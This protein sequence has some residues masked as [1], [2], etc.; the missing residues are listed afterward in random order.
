MRM[1]TDSVGSEVA[2][3]VV[4]GFAVHRA[5]QVLPAA[6]V[7]SRK[8]RTLLGLLA[9]HRD[10]VPADRITAAV[11]GGAP[12]RAPAANMA[13]LVSR[14]RTVLGRSAITGGPAG[15]R[16]GDQ[17]CVDL[18][19]AA[20]LT[21]A[22]EQHIVIQEADLAFTAARRATDLL[23]RG[24]VL[25]DHRDSWWAEEARALHGRLL[26]RARQATA[27]AALRIG[28]VRAARVAAEA[29][30]AADEL[31]EAAFRTLMRVYHAAEEPARAL[32]AYQRLRV[33]LA[34]ELGID[35]APAT[36]DLH[37][38]ILQGGGR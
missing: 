19:Q 25:A 23:D 3:R 14:L 22:A 35:P 37:T 1:F 10:F 28:D 33:T 26:R 29:A 31:D 30:T 7:G 18:F 13:T 27:E 12:P 4:G 34:T 15:Y 16:L 9:V 24:G 21:A 2:V 5:G 38:A 11:W 32:V 8:A 17:V 36:R 20:D 6:E